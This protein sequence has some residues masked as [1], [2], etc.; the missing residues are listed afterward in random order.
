MMCSLGLPGNEILPLSFG[1]KDDL[2]FAY[3]CSLSALELW[4]QGFR[5]TRDSKA[6]AESGEAT[7]APGTLPTTVSPGRTLLISVL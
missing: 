4:S 3:F 6:N 1:Q 5:E 2:L 7:E